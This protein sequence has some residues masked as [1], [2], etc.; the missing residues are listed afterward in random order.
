[1]KVLRISRN[2]LSNDSE[3]VKRLFELPGLQVLKIYKCSLKSI[4]IFDSSKT[5]L[6]EVNVGENDFSKD[7]DGVRRL[8][9]LSTLSFIRL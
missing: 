5:E 7:S 9:E 8:F 6:V 2:D 1:M 3:G 4:P